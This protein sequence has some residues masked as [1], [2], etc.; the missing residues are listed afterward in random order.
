VLNPASTRKEEVSVLTRAELPALPLA[1]IV[2]SSIA[3]G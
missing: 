2:T 3:R 1:R